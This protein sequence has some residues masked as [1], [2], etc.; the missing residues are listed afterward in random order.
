MR[1]MPLNTINRLLFH[2]VLAILVMFSL[3][4]VPVTAAPSAPRILVLNSYHE[5][6][7]WSDDEMAG[8]RTTLVNSFPRIEL[9]SEFL[10][11]KNFPTNSHFPRI[12]DLLASKYRGSRF[13]VIVVMDNAALEFAAR[14]RKRLFP[15]TPLVFCG[16]NDYTPSMLSGQSPITGVA[17][18]QDSVGTLAMALKLHPATRQ[19][20]VVS[21]YT[22]TGLAIRHELEI[23]SARFS[24]IKISYLEDMRLDQAV[25]TLK[26][27]PPDS[28]VLILSYAVEKGGRTFTQA[29]AAQLITSASPVPAYAIHAAQLG[30]GIVGG[31]LLA[32][33]I[34]G[35]K[36][37]ELAASVI[38]G[39]PADQLPVITASLSRTMFDY[40]AAQRFKVD[41]DNLPPDVQMINVPAPTY[42]IHKTAF[43]LGT[44]FAAAAS[45][46]LVIF[47]LNIRKRKRLEEELH[48]QTRLLEQEIAEH[49]TTEQALRTE[50]NNLK[51]IFESA[52]VGMILM[53]TGAVI[54]SVNNVMTN[55][56]DLAADR[57]IDRCLGEI[58]QCPRYYENTEACGSAT[59]CSLCPLYKAI[60]LALTKGKAVHGAE[61]QHDFAW[62]KVHLHPWIRY[63]VEPL[64]L[65]GETHVVI[66]FD[67]ITEKKELEEQL[68]ENEARLRLIFETSQS[69]MLLITP[70]GCIEYANN[71]TAEMFGCELSDLTRSSYADFIDAAEWQNG[72]SIMKKLLR[73]DISCG[74]MERNY[75]RKSGGS[76]WGY[77]AGQRLERGDGSL[78]AVV[79]SITDI[80]TL[81]MAV[82]ELRAE[83]ERL[84]VTLRSIGDG[85]ITT[86]TKGHVVLINRVAEELCGWNQEEAEGKPLE[87]VFRIISE[88]HRLPQ[89]NPVF[90][91]LSCGK[92]VELAN[93]TLLISRSGV[94]RSIA[95]SAA[96]ILNENRE[97]IG[98]VLVF[99]DMTEKKHAEEE[100]FK[101]RKL[102]SIGVLAGGIAHD[103][104]N[105]LTAILG[106]ISLARMFSAPGERIHDILEKA[107]TASNRA[108][109]LTQQLLTFAKG[110]SPVR[111]VASIG[112][113][114]TDSVSFVL[115]GSNVCYECNIDGDLNPV[116]V[117]AGQMSQV[118]NN[119]VINADQAMPDGGLLR[120]RAVN[121]QSATAAGSRSPAKS[122]VRITFEDQGVGIPAA[123]LNRI[124]D[125]YFSTKH[126]GSGLGLATV[127]SIIRKHH[128]D[129]KATSRLGEGTTFTIYLPAADG[130][131]QYPEEKNNTNNH[132]GSGRVLIMDD[133]EIIC[134]VL[135]DMLEL[136]G[137]DTETC[138]DGVEAVECYRKSLAA[139]N[140]FDAVIM[141]ITIPGGIGGKEAILMLKKIDPL[142]RAIVSSGYANDPIM[143]RCKEYGF[144]ATLAKPYDI[145]AIGDVLQ[146]VLSM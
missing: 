32:G 67:D 85:V 139:G 5:G 142:V 46:G 112:Q 4:A 106:N 117:D 97:I 58:L 48:L 141:D 53:N 120:I 54:V 125:P 47:Y 73:G 99:R 103:F 131:Q 127:Y 59:L 60:N 7:D 49:Q 74:Q 22:V 76:F 95:D 45:A 12:A 128:G 137:Y 8:L 51:A 65:D 37:A 80:S 31:K 119:L 9:F 77:V 29:E 94:E 43:W 63:S 30:H 11:T 140:A 39:T 55:L 40:L 57:V 17:E 75:L 116:E 115:R 101:A 21:D 135:S 129:I 13:D 18:N 92:I 126:Q 42:A 113:I 70:D 23:G 146:Q 108:K 33:S 66:A 56:L 44:L 105:Y 26:N 62:S 109:G 50:H 83:K 68:R 96:P 52:P 111:K 144:A 15:G 27:L 61:I 134:E 86:D 24:G 90:D 78:K 100:I 35:Q 136:M 41:L 121:E 19:V 6:Y 25:E 138:R 28:L 102:E 87:T 91:V 36:A 89:Q 3:E 133:E 84:A 145:T 10:D 118:I 79:V 110:G 107:E 72:A 123:H 143:A 38:R 69:G 34:Q 124:F 16:I 82:D 130:G 71:R 132:Q 93:H 122:Y 98:V 64:M 1:A 14:Y 20:L 104:N 81:K 2:G 88:A 114:I